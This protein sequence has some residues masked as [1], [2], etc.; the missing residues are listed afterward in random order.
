VRGRVHDGDEGRRAAPARL[1]VSRRDVG[2]GDSV[3]TRS[4]TLIGGV[5]E[6]GKRKREVYDDDPTA[7]HALRRHESEVVDVERGRRE[8]APV[9]DPFGELG[10]R[11]PQ[12]GHEHV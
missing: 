7:Q 11:W 10:D 12:H 2:F 4:W 3:V 8:A 5:D 9:D 1:P 6:H